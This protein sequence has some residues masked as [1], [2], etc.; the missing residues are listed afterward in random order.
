[1]T[2]MLRRA[3]FAAG[4][5]AL[6]AGPAG[7][8]E[9]HLP[10]S[11]TSFGLAQS[12]ASFQTSAAGIAT[13][14]REGQAYTYSGDAFALAPTQVT[15]TFALPQKQSFAAS[16]AMSERLALD[17]GY[18]LNLGERF[19]N[20][21][22]VRTPLIG[23]GGALALA[24]G[25]RYTGATFMPTSDLHVR[26]GL[27]MR[28]SRLDN[29]RFDPAT[30]L[31]LPLAFDPSQSRSVLAGVTWDMSDWASLG[32]D[33]IH[34]EQ[35]GLPY[36]VPSVL[37]VSSGHTDA[38]DMA[39]HFSL[40]NGWVTTASYSA[41]L[42]Q[43]DQRAAA[44]AVDSNAYSFAIAKHGLFGNDALGF[45]LSRP[46]PGLLEHGF[47]AVAANGN[48]PPAFIANSGIGQK[49]ETDLQLGYVTS[50]LN[51]VELQANAA[52]QMNYQGQTGATAVSLLSRAKIK[53]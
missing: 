22:A 30:R 5:A 28:D 11:L 17:Y 15:A 10:V 14:G 27:N 51:G 39:A 7:A 16:M 33:G 24:G 19:G 26:L 52:Y 38:V 47:D 45:S 3:I 53:F 13:L 37:G 44:P 40:G 6:A 23:T 48:L 49:D 34:H 35:N 50:F 43:L 18:G 25:G 36:G 29:F 12:L 42:T 20:F 9:L 2:T 32:V 21:D 46:M 4:M 1:M 31:E 41:G 8:A